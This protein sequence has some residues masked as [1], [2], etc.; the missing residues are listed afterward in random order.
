MQKYLY[1][2]ALFFINI[3]FAQQAEIA[4]SKRVDLDVITNEE[5]AYYENLQSNSSHAKSRRSDVY[6]K[7]REFLIKF[8]ITT[9]KKF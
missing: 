8:K 2:L 9:I 3:I 6:R 1:I 7:E 5:I 4:V